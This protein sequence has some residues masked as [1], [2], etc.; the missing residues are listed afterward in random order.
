MVAKCFEALGRALTEAGMR[1]HEDTC[2]A[3]TSDG[4]AVSAWAMCDRARV[5]SQIPALVAV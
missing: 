2:M 5:T 4:V 1:L 3:S